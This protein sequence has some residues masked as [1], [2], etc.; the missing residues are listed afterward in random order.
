MLSP[1]DVDIEHF[2]LS[3]T[4]DISLLKSDTKVHVK[5]LYLL[6]EH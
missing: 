1:E 5:M 6:G 3:L 2:L 4:Q